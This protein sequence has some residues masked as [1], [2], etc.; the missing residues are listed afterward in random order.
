MIDRILGGVAVAG[1]MLWVFW[2]ILV[3]LVTSDAG[4]WTLPNALYVLAIAY[5][6]G[7]GI[8]ACALGL[9]LLR[10]AHPGRWFSAGHIA[11]GHVL[12]DIDKQELPK[13]GV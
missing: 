12:T 10:R 8:V 1:S 7:L 2:W 11:L 5:G 6:G 3:P 13:S 9:G 4:D